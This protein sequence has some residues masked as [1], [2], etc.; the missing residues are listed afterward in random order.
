MIPLQLR[1]P[2]KKIY[3]Y[4]KYLHR[5]NKDFFQISKNYNQKPNN[6]HTPISR[7]IKKLLE[8]I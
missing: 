8:P 1:Y 7:S 5:E 2:M 4:I 6:P 3:E